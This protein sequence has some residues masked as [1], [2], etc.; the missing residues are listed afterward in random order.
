VLN[1]FFVALVLVSVLVAAFTGRMPAV[2]SASLDSAKKA[3][4]LALGLVGAMALFMGL[5]KV[6]QDAGLL[7]LLT[8]AT[9]PVMRRL[10]PEVPPEHPA[11]SAMV[12]S[13]ASNFLGLANAATPFGIRAM[14]ELERLN[15]V[16]GTATDPM[17]LFLA[18]TTS[19]LAILPT[20]VVA[21]RAAAGSKD[22]AGIFFTTWV[23]SGC[24]TVAAI[25]GARLLARLPRYRASDPGHSAA[26]AALPASGPAQESSADL[27]AAPV[28]AAEGDRSPPRYGAWWAWGYAAALAAALVIH[29]ARDSRD[30]GFGEAARGVLSYWMIPALIAGLVLFGWA[31]GVKVY[32]SFVEGAKEGFQVAIRI[33][34]Y[35]VAILVA[36]AM[37]RASGCLEAF[38]SVVSPFTEPLGLPAEAIPVAVLRPL[39]GSGAFAVMSEILT[40]RGPDTYLGYLVSTM[41]GSSDTTFYILA[42]Y[43]GAVGVKKTRHAVPAGLLVDL[44]GILA[45]IAVSRLFFGG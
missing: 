24:A 3:V 22:P 32:E 38:V 13:I 17:V 35:L 9:A 12:L 40:T 10:F 2:S 44:T 33:I 45:A 6:V 29:L 7:R 26:G 15:P 21:L 8:R 4:D 5:M 36:V 30:A 28:L 37:F 42:V 18:I 16:K 11:M 20:G 31:R 23:A 41:Q 43:F 39:S 19:G 14:Q 34:P 25:L 27:E 1:A